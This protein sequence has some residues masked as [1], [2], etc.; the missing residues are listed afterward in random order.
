MQQGYLFSKPL[1]A[2]AFALLLRTGSLAP[3]DA[4]PPA[5]S[6]T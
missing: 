4:V 3:L 2:E 6:E 5:V 1:P